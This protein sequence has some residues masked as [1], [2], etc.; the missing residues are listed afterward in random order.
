MCAYRNTGIRMTLR[1]LGLALAV[2][3]FAFACGDD[4]EVAFTF[5][6][7]T[8]DDTGGDAT[9]ERDV[10][11]D[12]GGEDDAADTAEDSGG[13]DTADDTAEDVADA[14]EDTDDDTAA[15]DTGDVGDDVAADAGDDVGDDA[16]DAGEDTEPDVPLRPPLVTV[17][18]PDDRISI[19]FGEPLTFEATLE[20]LPP[21][22]SVV[23]A[24]WISDLDGYLGDATFDEG[25]TSLL[26][27]ELGP[28]RHLVSL[29]VTLSTGATVFGDINVG[30]CGWPD[31]ETFDAPLVPSRWQVLGDA[32]RDERG[33]LE[34]TGDI[35]AR[36]GAILNVAQPVAS[37]DTNMR[38]RISTGHCTEPGPCGIGGEGAD[39]FAASIF[40]VEDPDDV[41]ALIEAAA[42]GG[43][44]G[45]A[46]A[47][48]YGD[49]DIDAFHIEFDTWYNRFNGSTEFHTDPTPMN[50][51]AITLNGDAG[52][53]ALWAPI[54][55][56]EDNGWHDVDVEIRGERVIVEWDGEVVIDDEIDGLAFKG[57]WIVFTGTT[58]YFTNHHRFDDLAIIEDCTY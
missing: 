57:G 35:R 9:V 53:H 54:D 16:T 42:T 26:V 36:K 19:A 37:G 47:G 44:L 27:E 43:G 23:T 50:H 24:Q 4:G 55:D 48:G 58:G 34:M 6:T 45:Y 31:T 21:D 22:A 15:P 30:V 11:T 32:A 1:T 25:A 46:V 3:T 33:W 13:E 20:Y 7:S 18:A 12:P 10:A 39:G 17:T 8:T 28:G 40:G 49:A 2:A 5:D 52:D 56:L 51:V 29:E 41:V 38:F 14:G